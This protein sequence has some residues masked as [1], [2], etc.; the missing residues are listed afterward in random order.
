VRKAKSEAIVKIGGKVRQL[1]NFPFPVPLAGQWR[2]YTRYTLDSQIIEFIKATEGQLETV[3]TDSDHCYTSGAVKYQFT[4][5]QSGSALSEMS[6]NDKDHPVKMEFC[7]PLS[8][9][10]GS[11]TFAIL[12]DKVMGRITGSYQVKKEGRSVQIRISPDGGWTSA[13]DTF[14]TKK[15]LAK[16]S[17]FCTWS[18][19][20]IYEQEI[21]LDTCVS[22][23]RW[24]KKQ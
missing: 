16:N 9:E 15:I 20:Y 12:P 2:Y 1:D 18:K 4:Q 3:E 14:I 11:G 24:Y 8:Y 5:T 10:T 7:P 22:K 21:N 17:I 13:P 23:S 19:K 6:I